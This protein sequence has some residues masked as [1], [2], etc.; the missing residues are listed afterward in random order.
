[1]KCDPMERIAPMLRSALLLSLCAQAARAQ[2]PAAPGVWDLNPEQR[3]RVSESLRIVGH[4][5][6]GPA[7]HWG[8]SCVAVDP[9]DRIWVVKSAADEIRV[10]EADGG[11][12]RAV[13]RWV[14]G[15][16]GFR[17]IGDAFSG[18]GEEIWVEDLSTLRYEIFDTAGTWVRGHPFVFRRSGGGPRVWTRQG[19]MVVRQ[20]FRNAADTVRLYE[21][22]GGALKRTR[23]KVVSVWP[24]SSTPT[25]VVETMAQTDTIGRRWPF[26]FALQDVAAREQLAVVS[27]SRR[28]PIPFAPRNRAFFGPELDLWV[29]YQIGRD[30]YQIRRTS[31]ETGDELLSMGIIDESNHGRESSRSGFP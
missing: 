29:A 15:R 17:N 11:F 24:E 26:P 8:V 12:V 20:G 30:R 21:L 5:G 6:G 9:M 19:L 7:V 3:W 14:E 28:A 27:I 13:G 4:E 23:P 16:G 2:E 10:F 22:A 1:M 31:L 18:P 25:F